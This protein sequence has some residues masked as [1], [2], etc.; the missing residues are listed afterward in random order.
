MR[1]RIIT[2]WIICVAHMWHRNILPFVTANISKHVILTPGSFQQFLCRLF[3]V[4]YTY[5]V[6]VLSMTDILAS[7]LLFRFVYWEDLP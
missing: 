7:L 4:Q 1:F 6:E 5:G 2:L 3:P